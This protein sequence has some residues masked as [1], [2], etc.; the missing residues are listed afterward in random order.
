[1]NLRCFLCL[2]ARYS[3]QAASWFSR[4]VGLVTRSPAL[5][6]SDLFS[7]HSESYQAGPLF[8]FL[9]AH[10]TRV[11]TRS[12]AWD[13]YWSNLLATALT[14]SRLHIHSII[15]LWYK[16]DSSSNIADCKS[17]KARWDQIYLCILSLRYPPAL[18]V[19]M[20]G[21]MMWLCGDGIWN[22]EITMIRVSSVDGY[23]GGVLLTNWQEWLYCKY[24]P[25]CKIYNSIWKK[26]FCS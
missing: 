24:P 5:I 25:F 13:I 2:V 12:H 15:L 23:Y 7:L 8:L 10:G 9:R 6:A 18:P 21:S 17:S 1:M 14:S 16:T 19:V 20:K 22:R 4:C 11:R 26:T 3:R